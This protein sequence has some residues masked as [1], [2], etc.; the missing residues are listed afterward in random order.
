ML[1]PAL[2]NNDKKIRKTGE[3]RWPESSYDKRVPI[4]FSEKSNINCSLREK[5]IFTPPVEFSPKIII[6]KGSPSG[7][8]V[9]G[10]YP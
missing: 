2:L 6:S 10:M 4:K 7:A 3:W 5:S 8:N 1:R 9:F